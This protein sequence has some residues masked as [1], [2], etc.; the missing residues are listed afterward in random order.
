MPKILE[1]RNSTA[2]FLTFLA[3]NRK[4]GVQVIYMDETIWATQTAMGELFDVEPK[5]IGFHLQNIFNE[6]ELQQNRT[7]QKIGVVQLEGTRNVSRE[8][9]FQNAVLDL[10]ERMANRHI[11]MTM[12]DWARRIDTILEAGGDRI[13]TDAGQISAEFAKEYAESEFEKYRVIQDR[14]FSSDFDKF[15][16]EAGLPELPFETEEKKLTP[17]DV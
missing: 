11:P 8:P 1:I 6:G 15:T 14:L 3:E 7:T 12:E 16:L 4:E 2:E 5:T 13:L 10:A 17:I 9:T